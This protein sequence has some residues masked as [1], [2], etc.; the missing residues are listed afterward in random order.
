[1]S[2]S[3]EGTTTASRVAGFLQVLELSAK[4]DDVILWEFH[5][6]PDAL[7]GCGLPSGLSNRAADKTGTL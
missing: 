2:T 1:M 5:L 6:L 4:F 3:A 7:F